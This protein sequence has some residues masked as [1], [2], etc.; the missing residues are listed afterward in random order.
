MG[1]L[2]SS[3]LGIGSFHFFLTGSPGSSK[4]RKR[5]ETEEER[6]VRKAKEREEKEERYRKEGKRPETEEERRARKEKERKD[7][8]AR[9]SNGRTERYSL[10]LTWSPQYRFSTEGDQQCFD[11]ALSMVCLAKAAVRDQSL[12]A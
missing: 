11:S 5:P 12:D 9:K 8:E 7:K 2:A 4:H 10:W 6:R 1:S 3:K